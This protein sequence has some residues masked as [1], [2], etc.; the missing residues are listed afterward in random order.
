MALVEAEAS[1]ATGARLGGGG[2]RQEE[3]WLGGSMDWG[4]D[5]EIPRWET[6][7][8]SVAAGIGQGRIPRN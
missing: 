7:R 8:W 2:R 4:G 5:E 1:S 3:L 6:T